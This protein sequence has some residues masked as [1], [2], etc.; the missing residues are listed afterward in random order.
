V[1]GSR[2]SYLRESYF[3]YRCKECG[4]VEVNIAE[5]SP[6]C[7]KSTEHRLVRLGGSFKGRMARKAAYEASKTPHKKSLLE[8]WVLRRPQP[9]I[10]IEPVPDLDPVVQW[11]DHEIYD[12]AYECPKCGREAL[13]FKQT[14]LLFD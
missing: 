14:G 12:E 3:P 4:I 9:V 13:R 10:P 7:P 2:H 1:G 6:V 11:G 8:R 5:E